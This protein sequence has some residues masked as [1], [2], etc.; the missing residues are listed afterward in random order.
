MKLSNFFIDELGS[1]SLKAKNSTIYLLSGIMVTDQSRQNLRIKADQIKFK[2]WGH[3][4]IIFHSRD[5]GRNQGDFKIFQNKDIRLKFEKDLL[6]FLKNGQYQLFTVIVDKLKVPPSWNEKK[7][8]KV[9]ANYLIKSFILALLA[10]KNLK[11]RLVIES[12]TAE[13]DFYY[14]KSASNFLSHGFPS[15]KISFKEVQD[16]LT[17]ISFVTKKNYD[18][19]EQIADILAYGIRLKYENRPNHL[20]FYEQSLIKTVDIKLFKINPN[21]GIR[22]KKL[23]S[24]ISSYK[25]I[26]QK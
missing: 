5:I 18:I 23:Y 3:T 22:K 4:N 7:I 19:E 2:Y 16:I 21:T 17:E 9:T 1:A 6:S 15:L 11:G 12:A 13:K 25:I 24:N 8:Y 14:H 10:Q 20:S 26:G